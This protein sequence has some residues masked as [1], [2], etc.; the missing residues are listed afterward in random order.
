LSYITVL[1]ASCMRRKPTNRS[2]SAHENIWLKFDRSFITAPL[3][4]I[5]SITIRYDNDAMR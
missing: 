2:M 1:I 5:R 3:M 4:G